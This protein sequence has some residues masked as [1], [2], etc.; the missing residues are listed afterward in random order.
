M[1]KLSVIITAGDGV[2]LRDITELMADVRDLKPSQ[3]IVAADQQHNSIVNQ[4]KG[5]GVAVHLVD[6]GP[7]VFA[8]RTVCANLAKGDVLLFLDSSRRIPLRLLL[9]FVEPA[10]YGNADAVLLKRETV[11]SRTALLPSLEASLAACWNRFL[12]KDDLMASDLYSAPFALSQ[13]SIR[14]VGAQKLKNPVMFYTSLLNHRLKTAHPAGITEESIGRRGFDP[15]WH[16][17]LPTE[18]SAYERRLVNHYLEAMNLYLRKPRGGFPDGGRRRDI[19]KS[20]IRKPQLFPVRHPAAPLPSSKLYKGKK[21]S[22]VIPAR[23]EEATISSVIAEVR[24]LEPTEIIV[25]DNGSQ[26]AT[27]QRALQ[28]GAAVVSAAEA[29]GTD[30]GRAVGA[31]YATG[32]IVLFLDAEPVIAAEDLYPFALAVQRG[33]DIAL[34]D[35]NDCRAERWHSHAAAPA[36]YA[37]N[38]ALDHKHLGAASMVMVPFALS[39]KALNRIGAE[40]LLCPP[41]AFALGV[42]SGLRAEAVHRVDV[43]SRNRPRLEHATGEANRKIIGDHIEAFH[44]VLEKKGSQ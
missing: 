6:R 9:K 8:S 4:A 36:M 40:P 18:L 29:L 23:N 26:D 2:P 19:L 14:A 31:L 41:R 25:V 1:R 12:G 5:S 13:R 42:L 28:S 32:E 10:L 27:A 3:V 43:E 35:L 7:D 17:S 21:L 38:A 39:R 16:G 15:Y 24:N 34:N 22:V 30:T 11:R 33:V 37:L 20:L 44:V